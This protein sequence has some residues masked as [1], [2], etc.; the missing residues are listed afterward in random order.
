MR[1]VTV[2]LAAIAL[3]LSTLSPASA[4]ISSQTYEVQVKTQTNKFRVSADRAKVSPSSCLD[5][6]AESWARKLARERRL[7]HRDA[8]GMRKVMRDCN[9]NV[10][11]ENMAEGYSSGTRTVIAWQNSPGHRANL[12]NQAVRL[13]ASGAVYSGDKW[14]VVQLMG[15]KA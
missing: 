7:V 6:W 4:R 13:H 3:T 12:L 14:W 8:A 5:R 11:T 10:L 15:R 2:T 1:I 9:L